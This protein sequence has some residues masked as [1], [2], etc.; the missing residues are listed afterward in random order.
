MT[1]TTLD[2]QTALIVVDLQNGIVAFT[3]TPP[4]HQVVEK[5]AI[6]AE[7]FRHHGLPCVFVNVTGGAPGRVDQPRSATTLPDDWADLVPELNV[8]ADEHRVTK[9]T[10]APLPVP[11]WRPI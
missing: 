11:I 7:A 5:T 3:T 2:A 10:W 6:L 9:K 8:R 1:I 4:T